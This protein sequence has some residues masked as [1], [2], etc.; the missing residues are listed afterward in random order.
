MCGKVIGGHPHIVKAQKLNKMTY[1]FLNVTPVVRVRIVYIIYSS[2]QL[3]WMTLFVVSSYFEVGY[4][5]EDEG[6]PC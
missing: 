3:A 6:R 4:F 2:S 5:I 1:G